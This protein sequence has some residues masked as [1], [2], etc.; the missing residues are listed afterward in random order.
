MVRLSLFVL[1]FFKNMLSKDAFGLLSKTFSQDLKSYVPIKGLKSH[2]WKGKCN[3]WK[4]CGIK[5]KNGCQPFQVLCR[6]PGRVTLLLLNSSD[7]S[8]KTAVLPVC[9]C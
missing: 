1:V 8:A 3:I 6:Q 9:V 5:N 7:V 4:V 2:L